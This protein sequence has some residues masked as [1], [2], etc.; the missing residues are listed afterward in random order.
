MVVAEDWE[1]WRRDLRAAA[2]FAALC[3]L[4]MLA[5]GASAFALIPLLVVAA[6]RGVPSR[7]WLGIAALV[8][9]ALLAPWSAYQRFADPPGNRLIKWQIG[10]SLEIDDRGLLETIV[11]GY[12]EV[13]LDGA[14]RQQAGKRRKDRWPEG[15]RSGGS[16][17]QSTVGE[18]HPGDAALALR[19]PRFFYAAALPRDP[20]TGTLAML[21]AGARGSRDGP[22]WRFPLLSFAFCGLT[23][24]VWVLLMFGE[25][26]GSTTIHQGTLVLPLLAVCACVVGAYAVSPRFA[27]A[28]APG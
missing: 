8:G 11:D 7:R 4:A 10:G 27:I 9:V 3:A 16:S 17:R 28:L 14:P 26:G 12:R 25:R 1:R 22:E 2:L 24:A 13:G 5:H 20:A 21:V 18:G 23:T 6:V 19:F 15:N